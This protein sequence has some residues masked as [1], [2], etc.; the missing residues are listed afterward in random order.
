MSDELLQ[1]KLFIPLI[2]PNLVPRPHLVE[3]L[4]RKL[5]LGSKVTLL[6]APAGFGKTTLVTSWLDQFELKTAWL[7]LDEG[8]ND[9]TRFISYL[10]AAL[11]TSDID[12]NNSIHTI[13]ESPHFP[14]IERQLGALINELFNDKI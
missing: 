10:F 6:S 2:R 4:K 8:D 5:D 11:I 7:S 3:Q 1:T 13:L 9:P 12:I 14:N